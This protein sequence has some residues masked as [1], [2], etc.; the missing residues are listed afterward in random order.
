MESGDWA[1]AI[2]TTISAVV[3][4]AT[5]NTTGASIAASGATFSE[6]DEDANSINA[7]AASVAGVGMGLGLGGDDEEL[8]WLNKRVVFFVLLAIYLMVIVGGVLGNGSILM[9]LF[10]SGRVPRNP[11]LVALCLSDFFVSGLSA[12]IT[13]ITSAFVQNTWR[14]GSSTCMTMYFFQVSGRGEIKGRFI[15]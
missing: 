8:E 2:T 12:P 1:A 10:T 7:T 15:G 11:L 5:A 6:E 3:V 14:A 4:V 9:T 13:V